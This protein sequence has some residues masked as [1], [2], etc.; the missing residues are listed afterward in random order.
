MARQGKAWHP[1]M[2]PWESQDEERQILPECHQNAGAC[3]P[4]THL[5]I[6]NKLI[7]EIK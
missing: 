5:Y 6:L 1:D 2:C 7:L 4:N 3:M